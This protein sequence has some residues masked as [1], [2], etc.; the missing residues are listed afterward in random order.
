MDDVKGEDQWDLQKEIHEDVFVCLGVRARVRACVL[1]GHCN[2]I[3]T[4][5]AS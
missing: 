1:A 5:V 4:K 2:W 3:V